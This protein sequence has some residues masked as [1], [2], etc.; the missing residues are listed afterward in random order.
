MS[1]T[2]EVVGQIQELLRVAEQLDLVG[3][4]YTWSNTDGVL[5][6]VRQEPV[7]G[8]VLKEGVSQEEMFVNLR[9][10]LQSMVRERIKAIEA[11]LTTL[12]E[13]AK[14]AETSLRLAEL[15]LPDA[16]RLAEIKAACERRGT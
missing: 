10:G 14:K 7:F 9:D 8:V 16:E 15:V 2:T 6:V 5:T 1:Q 13:L 3:A 4:R 11:E 12:A